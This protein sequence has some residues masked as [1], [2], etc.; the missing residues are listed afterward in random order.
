M[1]SLTVLILRLRDNMVILAEFK[2]N[3]HVWYHIT[4][5]QNENLIAFVTFLSSVLDDIK[6]K[7]EDNGPGSNQFPG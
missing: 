1:H 3:N 6:P 4:Y 5:L 2:I 7:L